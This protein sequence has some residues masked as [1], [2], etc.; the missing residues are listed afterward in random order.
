MLNEKETILRAKMYL[1][2]LSAGIDPLTDSPIPVSDTVRKAGISKCLSYAA[3]I[4]GK[5]V[6][7]PTAKKK[8]KKQPFSLTPEKL[9]EYKITDSLPVTEIKNRLNALLDEGMAKLKSASVTGWLVDNG[10]LIHNTVPDGKPRFVPTDKGSNTGIFVE[11][12]HGIHGEYGVLLYDSS[13]QQL[14]LDNLENIAAQDLKNSER[15]TA[16][17][18]QSSNSAVPDTVQA[19]GSASEKIVSLYKN[20]SS[21]AAI[22]HILKIDYK[23]IKNCLVEAG[24]LMV[25]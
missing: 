7:Q 5:A 25:N 23:V 14:I 19:S 16:A 6:E 13:A 8:S 2:K 24:V 12:R 17:T 22:A 21:I 15:K 20:G 11:I 3:E 10:Y 18:D 9:S 1:E 4:L